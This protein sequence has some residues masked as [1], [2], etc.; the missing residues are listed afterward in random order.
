MEYCRET[1]YTG[2]KWEY[3][4]YCKIEDNT[5]I[6]HKEDNSLFNNQMGI[7]FNAP[8]DIDNS[9]M[10]EEIINDLDYLGYD[11]KIQ[12]T[13]IFFENT[14]KLIPSSKGFQFDDTFG[15]SSVKFFFDTE[16][17]LIKHQSFINSQLNEEIIFEYHTNGNLSYYHYYAFIS[18]EGVIESETFDEIEF[19]SLQT[20]SGRKAYRPTQKVWKSSKSESETIHEF[21]YHYN[22]IGLL[23]KERVIFKRDTKIRYEGT[24]TI[25]YVYDEQNR[26]IK[27]EYNLFELF[28]R[29]GYTDDEWQDEFFKKLKHIGDGKYIWERSVDLNLESTYFREYSEDLKSRFPN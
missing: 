29:S 22:E 1:K 12:M 8:D 24:I 18:D 11:L 19:L 10:L 26:W 20:K 17:R 5:I 3:A 4:F 14:E 13:G 7:L 25:L 9:K 27:R 15:D 21:S 2:R 28:F 6:E 23:E 16:K